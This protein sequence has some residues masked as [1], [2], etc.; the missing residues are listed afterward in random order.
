M[1]LLIEIVNPSQD[2]VLLFKLLMG[3]QKNL[4]DAYR[5]FGHPPSKRFACPA[6][7]A[8][9]PLKKYIIF[10]ILRTRLKLQN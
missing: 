9:V 10:A 8:A 4:L 3:T 2:L 7:G 6:L 1:Q 5:Q